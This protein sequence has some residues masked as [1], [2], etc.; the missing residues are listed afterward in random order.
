MTPRFHAMVDS[1]EDV[2]AIP[3]PTFMVLKYTSFESD[4]FVC[5]FLYFVLKKN[6]QLILK[7]DTITGGGT[8]NN[9]GKDRRINY[10]GTI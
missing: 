6:L 10:K 2:A 9:S 4:I 3:R 5:P 7:C 8:W 1:I